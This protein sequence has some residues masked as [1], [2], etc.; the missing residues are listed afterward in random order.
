MVV[1]VYFSTQVAM[2]AVLYL[3]DHFASFE[4]A[5]LGGLAMTAAAAITAMLFG[6]DS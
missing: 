4:A 5:V 3:I 1:F 6:D 2:L